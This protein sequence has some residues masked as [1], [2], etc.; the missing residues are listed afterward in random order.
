[1]TVL[2][3]GAT[4]KTG[5]PVVD[6]LV[7]RGVDVRAASRNPAAVTAGVEPVRFDWA[8]R[9][10]WVPALHGIDSLYVVGP[11]AA[12][13][14]PG[15]VGDLLATA[16]HVR[17][18]VLLSVLGVEQLPDAIPMAAWE[19]DVR[20]SGKQW[21]IL[22]PNWFQQNF[23]EGFAAA[24][25]ENGELALPVADAAVGFVDTRDIAEVAVA[26]LTEEG[27]AGEVHIITGPEALTLRQVT[28]TLGEAAGRDLGYVP[29]TADQF[30]EGLRQAGLDERS[31]T[32][33][34]GLF[35]LIR[36][37]GN[38]VVTDTVERLTGHPARQLKSYALEHAA[39]W[40]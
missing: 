11:Y 1:M 4:G 20:A 21:T 28:Q 30:A 29:I 36:D 27:H 3:L 10:T 17:K 37:G 5:R 39:T 34:Q 6:A 25:R 16:A 2:V 31:I 18:V 23:G 24:L 7:A 15:L 32:W 40:R 35:R 8:D 14:E 22:R 12:P 33:Q 38:A 9:A 19:A 26:A 13:E